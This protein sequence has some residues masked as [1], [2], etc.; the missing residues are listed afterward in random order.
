MG[1]DGRPDELAW[2]LGGEGDRR[3]LAGEQPA[4]RHPEPEDDRDASNEDGE[5]RSDAMREWQ[6][7]DP[8]ENRDGNRDQHE[9][10]PHGRN[11]R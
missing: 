9:V 8:S 3:A 10:A 2:D 6:H 5:F 11:D 7:D 1:S 4:S